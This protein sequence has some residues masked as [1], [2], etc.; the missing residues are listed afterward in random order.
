MAKKS[1]ITANLGCMYCSFTCWNYE[2]QAEH[3]LE[4]HSK[5]KVK[6]EEGPPYKCIYCGEGFRTEEGVNHHY[7]TNHQ[8]TIL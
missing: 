5:N 6:V 1:K 3:Y 7:E 4:K 2:Q 8:G